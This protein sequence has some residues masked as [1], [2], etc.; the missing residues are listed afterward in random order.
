MTSQLRTMREPSNVTGGKGSEVTL[1]N[2]AGPR[3]E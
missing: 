3:S 1:V 2:D